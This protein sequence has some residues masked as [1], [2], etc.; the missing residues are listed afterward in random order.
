[1]KTARELKDEYKKMKFRIG[2]F[3]IRN[4]KNDKCFIGSSQDLDAA[5]NSQRFQLE[6]GLHS[7]EELQNDWAI[8]GAENFVYEVLDELQA[9]DDLSTDY[10]KELKALEELVIEELQPFGEKGYNRRKRQPT[11]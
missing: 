6:A 11:Y 4:I 9:D 7:N 1:M 8:L 10:T 3:R 5:W 2:V